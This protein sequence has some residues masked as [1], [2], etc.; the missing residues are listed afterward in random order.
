MYVAAKL[1][2]LSGAEYFQIDTYDAPLEQ[3]Q[4][5]NGLVSVKYMFVL[6]FPALLLRYVAETKV[7]ENSKQTR[8]S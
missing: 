3:R 1:F 2:E 6:N 8:I 5:K 4:Y 7:R